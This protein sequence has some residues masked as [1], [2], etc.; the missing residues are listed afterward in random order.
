MILPR[1]H[2]YAAD[3]SVKVERSAQEESARRAL[4]RGGGARRADH[5]DGR[6]RRVCVVATER[7]YRY[8]DTR[9]YATLL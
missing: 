4:L 6:V 8:H 3:L 7:D 9:A 1:C 2:D 5:I